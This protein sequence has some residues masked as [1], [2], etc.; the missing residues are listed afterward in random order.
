MECRQKID[1]AMADPAI[2]W[3]D[4]HKVLAHSCLELKRKRE[5]LAIYSIDVP[6]C[7]PV[8]A[9]CVHPDLILRCLEKDLGVFI[10]MR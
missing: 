1:T 10:P 6:A 9:S 4:V 2:I 8:K 7:M 3:R 5:G